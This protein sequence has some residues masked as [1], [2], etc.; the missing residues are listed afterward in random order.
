VNKE[1]RETEVCP[2]PRVRLVA[3]V[4]AAS[5]EPPVLWVLQVPLVYRVP[6]VP[7]EQRVHLVPPVRRETLVCSDLPVLL[8]HQER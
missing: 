6:K 5:V 8:A 7:R 3:R 1:R 2:D 4:I